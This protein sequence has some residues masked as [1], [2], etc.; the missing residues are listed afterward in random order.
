MTS[1]TANKLDH[2]GP[3]GGKS[4]SFDGN[5]RVMAESL[6]KLT[7]LTS[8]EGRRQERTHIFVAATLY[9]GNGSYPVHIRNMSP[10]GA[11]VEGAVLP[12]QGAAA[13]LR[14]GALEARAEL[15]WVAGRK[16]GL[17]FASAVQVRDWMS[18][19]PPAHQGRVDERVRRIR[20]GL[21]AEMSPAENE[22]NGPASPTIEAELKKL[23]RELAD[24][25]Q[26]LSSD[27]ALVAAHPE[28]Q[29]LDPALQR[30]DRLIAGTSS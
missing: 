16:A 14:R 25:E 26:G 17:S 29:L 6:T 30:L 3:T 28:I 8:D 4:F 2:F 22:L 10:S 9:F 12:E 13:M 15:V 18:R 7:P 23:R 21:D 20:A 27:A 24:L 5:D 1:V 19:T 11:L